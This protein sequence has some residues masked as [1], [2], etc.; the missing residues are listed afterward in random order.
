MKTM[1]VDLWGDFDKS[2]VL[3]SLQFDDFYT[4]TIMDPRIKFLVQ[5]YS[6]LIIM[7]RSRD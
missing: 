4:H 3:R 1:T 5:S 2:I 7:C 6:K